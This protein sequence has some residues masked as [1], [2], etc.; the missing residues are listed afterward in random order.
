MQFD[1][2]VAIGVENIQIHTNI[3]IIF[4]FSFFIK[5]SFPNESQKI[6][7]TSGSLTLHK[8]TF[9]TIKITIRPNIN[10]LVFPLQY[11]ME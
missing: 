11:G 4:N 6:H 5:L 10:F 7:L 9:I 1:I 2:T 8:I 3:T